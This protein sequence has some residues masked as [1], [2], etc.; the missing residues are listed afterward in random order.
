MA[1]R[2]AYQ[3]Q[4][5]ERAAAKEAGLMTYFTG[6]PCKYGH[7][8][9]RRV[10]NGCCVVCEAERT[11]RWALEHPEAMK[12]ATKKSYAKHSDA[13]RLLAKKYREANPE[14]TKEAQKRKTPER[15]AKHAMLES[16]RQR[17]LKQ[18]TPSWLS[19][20]DKKC[21]E[22][23]YIESAKME[24]ET[25]VDHIVPVKGKTVCGLHVPW[26]LCIRT[27]SDNSKKI[28]KLTEDAYLPKQVGILIMASALPWN[29]KKETQNV[30]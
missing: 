25:A 22:Q 5:K 20:E 17:R 12:L 16:I 26:N 6:K 23:I 10:S 15:K 27:K 2:P 13:R 29:L 8:E 3:F 7:I 14:K 30:N 4:P 24:A 1:I 21:I 28:N 19:D 11:R 9:K 18:A